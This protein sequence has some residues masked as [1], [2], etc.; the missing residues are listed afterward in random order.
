VLNVMVKN[1]QGSSKY[2]PNPS[3]GQLESSS[4]LELGK[5]LQR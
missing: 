3:D 4:S 5:K 1:G 2:Q